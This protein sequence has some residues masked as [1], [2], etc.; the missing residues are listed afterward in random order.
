M[1][2][3]TTTIDVPVAA[4]LTLPDVDVTIEIERRGDRLEMAGLYAKLWDTDLNRFREAWVEPTDSPVAEA[5]WNAALVAFE[6][7]DAA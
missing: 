4:G 7:K 1:A 6:R 3:Y 2:D 5:I